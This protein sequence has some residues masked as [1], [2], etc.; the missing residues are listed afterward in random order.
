MV[1]Q[2]STVYLNTPKGWSLVA[3]PVDINLS[4]N[5]LYGKFPKAN[6]IWLYDETSWKALGGTLSIKEALEATG[7]DVIENIDK[8][9]GF[10][11]NSS[12]DSTASF[13]GDSYNVLL[14]EKLSNTSKGWSLLGTA[15]DISVNDLV[16]KNNS[17]KTIWVYDN[18]W[19]AYSPLSSTQTL[20]K[21]AVFNY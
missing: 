9:K 14:S 20:W 5:D 10:W 19:K 21:T 17:I 11:I 13:S 4:Q 6:T 18:G 8:Y 12:A 1:N 7:I 3:L 16:S 15:E 2:G